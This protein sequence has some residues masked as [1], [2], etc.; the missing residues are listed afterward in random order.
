MGQTGESMVAKKAYNNEVPYR[1]LIQYINK[2]YKA[3]QEA[4]KTGKGEKAF[5]DDAEYATDVMKG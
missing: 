3:I 5:K 2:N 4:L 1:K